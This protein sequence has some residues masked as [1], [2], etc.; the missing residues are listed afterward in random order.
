MNRKRIRIATRKSPLALRQTD[1][2]IEALQE[3][4]PELECERVLI[5]TTGDARQQWSLSEKGGKGLFTKEIEDALLSGEADLAV[6]SAKDLPTEVPKG[7]EIRG[8]LPRE[9]PRDVLVMREGLEEGYPKEIASA[10]PRRRIQGKLLFPNAV[11]CEIRGNVDTRIK[12]IA[13]GAT[14]ATFL[15]AAGLNRL[16]IS[17]WDGTTFRLLPFRVMVPA[18]GQAAIALQTRLGDL[19]E[20]QA[21]CCPATGAAVTLER[22]LLELM[23]GGCQIAMGAHC[24]GESLHVFHEAWGYQQIHLQA[25]DWVDP[26]PLLRSLIDR[27]RS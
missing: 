16:G 4:F 11:W 24:D 8:F 22:R 6:H 3:V 21:V 26:E 10:S 27:K 25:S 17:S 5:T 7:L 15:A 14:D 9:D 19:E 2:V 18:V 13:S 20:L 12:K 23:E 1:L